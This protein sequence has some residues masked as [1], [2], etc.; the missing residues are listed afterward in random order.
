MRKMSELPGVQD[1]SDMIIGFILFISPW[2]LKFSD[3]DY[4]SW[5]A[6]LCGLVIV[7][8][9]AYSLFVALKE[10]EHWNGVAIGAWLMAA[11]WVLDFGSI[12]SATAVH[13]VLGLFLILSEAWEIR[14]YRHQHDDDKAVAA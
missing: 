5:N 7:I 6:W 11:P 12:R 1:W 8:S 14:A 13:I 3:L 4:P 2:V 9:A 10:W